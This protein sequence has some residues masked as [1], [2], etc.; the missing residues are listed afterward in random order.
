MKVRG[1]VLSLMIGGALLLG[2]CRREDAGD[3]SVG[4]GGQCVR[5]SDCQPDLFCVARMCVHALPS[6]VPTEAQAAPAAQAMPASD[7]ASRVE[8]APVASGRPAYA[9]AAPVGTAAATSSAGGLTW[10]SV[11]A[12]AYQMGCSPNDDMCKLDEMP[13][14]AVTL[15][16]FQILETEV[17]EGQYREAMGSAPDNAREGATPPDD[18]VTRVVWREAGAFCRAVGGRLPTEAEWEYAAR[19][20]AKTRFECGD[21]EACLDASEWYDGNG[22]NRKHPVRG[23]AANGYGLYDM[24]GN[25]MEWTGD[26]Y[27]ERT[28]ANSPS[29][30]PQ[31][32]ADGDVRVVRGGSYRHGPRGA[33]VSDRHDYDKGI[34]EDYVGFR[35][36]R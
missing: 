4:I 20:G 8:G 28:Y 30:D 15:S 21:S 26:A 32:P 22:E 11:P 14:H 6:S 36:V 10:I 1:L 17:T 27:D 23:K 24:S 29:T 3:E 33:R 5:A 16:A 25:V 19:S 7:E 35:C 34:F 9:E 2:A 18:P 13:P 12:G 31:G